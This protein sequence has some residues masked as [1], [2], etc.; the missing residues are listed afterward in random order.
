MLNVN[1]LNRPKTY[2]LIAN[3][4]LVFFLILLGNFKVVP[5]DTGDFVFFALLVFMLAIYRSGWAFL[6]FV[7]LI[8][9]EN[10]NL[11]PAE[12]EMTIRPYQ[13]LGTFIIA[14]LLV[15]FFTKRL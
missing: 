1:H 9:L 13:F 2:L 11:A 15:R 4:L 14:A 6:I 12:L 8:P 7:G 3:V 10:I 5:L